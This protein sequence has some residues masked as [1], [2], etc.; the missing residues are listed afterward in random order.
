M[1][2][3]PDAFRTISEVADWLGI[4]AHV[5]RFWESKFT[6]VKPVK[7]AGGRRYYRP[8]DMLLLGGIK[9]LL[10]DDGLTIKGVQKI[11]R[12]E[13]MSHVSALSPPL[14]DADMEAELAKMEPVPEP[15]AKLIDVPEREPVSVVLPFE[16]P[17]PATEAPVVLASKG[18]TEE[19][20]TQEDKPDET[21]TPA[22]TAELPEQAKQT[23][24]DE[25]APAAPPAVEEAASDVSDA[26]EAEAPAPKVKTPTEPEKGAVEPVQAAP[27]VSPEAPVAADETAE[28]ATE[29]SAPSQSV[30]PP[31]ADE[32]E[33][34]QTTAETAPV[35]AED[36]P[37]TPAA[38]DV[39][40]APPPEPA[41][42][43]A[44][45][46][47]MPDVTPE[48]EIHAEIATLARASRMRA[49]D[50]A[51]AQKMAPL[52]VQLADLRDRMAARHTGV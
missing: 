10:H 44:R 33:T 37:D 7:R 45:D 8:A 48:D 40:P 21:D 51:S 20:G 47:G 16:A 31:D 26:P 28:V 42:P 18:S 4:Q 17:K 24:A 6:Q 1:S 19:V 49:I 11:L 25:P 15:D 5:L 41:S 39:A 36:R 14:D 9:K 32:G 43:K 3:S 13:G 52:L 38:A 29:A 12:E 50:A 46:I 35:P 22:E 27:E 30:E 2:K 34:A 23:V